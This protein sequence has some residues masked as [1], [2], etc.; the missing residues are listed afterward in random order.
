MT[1]SATAVAEST[2]DDRAKLVVRMAIR[3]FGD[4]VRAADWLVQAHDLFAG[5]SRLSVAK[6]SALGCTRVCAMLD[7]CAGARSAFE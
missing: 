4:G 2:A 6:E 5:R 1:D 3:A 7:E